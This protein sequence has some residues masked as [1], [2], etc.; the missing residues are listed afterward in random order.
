MLAREYTV[1][2]DEEGF[3]G[4]ESC[5]LGMKSLITGYCYSMLSGNRVEIEAEFKS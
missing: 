4:P 1:L 5:V 3:V 2:T